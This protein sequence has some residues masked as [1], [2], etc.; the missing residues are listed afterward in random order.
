MQRMTKKGLAVSVYGSISNFAKAMGWSYRKANSIINDKQEPTATE[1]DQMAE[2]FG[3]EMP[4]AFK[5]LFVP[6]N[7]QN[8]DS[9]RQEGA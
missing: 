3:I 5:D 1:V 7:P 9:D 2:A 4:R 8:V 6:R